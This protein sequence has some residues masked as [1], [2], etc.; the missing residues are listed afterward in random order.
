MKRFT[1]IELLVV[2]A[3]IAILAAM[4]LPALQQAKKKAE[5]SNCTN[6]MK[7]LGSASHLYCGE[8]KA[9]YPGPNPFGTGGDYTNSKALCWDGEA[10]MATWDILLAITSGTSSVAIQDVYSNYP[11][12]CKDIKTLEMFSCP[13]AVMS[14]TYIVRSYSLNI[15]VLW[16]GTMEIHPYD[17]TANGT[18]AIPSTM[19]EEAA[20]TVQLLEISNR[21]SGQVDLSV[22]A[23]HRAQSNYTCAEESGTFGSGRWMRP[24]RQLYTIQPQSF[25]AHGTPQDARPNALMYDGH[26]ELT[27]RSWY[28]TSPRVLM[29]FA[30]NKN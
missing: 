20:G 22:F 24:L 14:T 23:R 19:I 6:N 8:N 30:Y 18:T 28:Q 21:E 11:K 15:G 13:A 3:I 7:Q 12:T 5:Q 27:N 10:S 4:L 25:Y 17:P 26:V 29:P 1:L 2:I 16:G 9:Y